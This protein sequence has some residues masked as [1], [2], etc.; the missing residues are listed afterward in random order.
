M[1]LCHVEPGCQLQKLWMFTVTVAAEDNLN[2]FK[3]VQYGDVTTFMPLS[4]TVM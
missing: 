2:A 1:S 3:A 4:F